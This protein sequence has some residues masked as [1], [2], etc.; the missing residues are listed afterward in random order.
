MKR[1]LF[2]SLFILFVSSAH[3]QTS[4]APIG[5]RLQAQVSLG[6][7]YSLLGSGG[8][9]SR[10]QNLRDQGL[11]YY[12]NPTTGVR[13]N[14][15]SYG[16]PAGQTIGLSFHIPV[17]GVR[18]LLLGGSVHTAMTGTQPSTGGYEEGY[19]FNY[20]LAGLSAKY[21]PWTNDGWFMQLDGGLG[22]V[23]TKNRFK[24]DAGQQRF[25]HQFGIGFGGGLSVGYT[26]LPFKNKNLG[27]EFR[28]GYQ[29]YSTRVEVDG[30]GD[31]AWSFG[32]AGVQV[33]L[34]WLR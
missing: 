30:L 18:G 25:F 5:Q 20:L 34:V 4:S 26:L 27:L 3:G 19:F 12:A 11:S 17:R 13:A 15:G 16:T 23:F 31:D 10:S 1:F 7:S 24:N 6:W 29:L 32:S 2:L 9:L 21:Y 8:E 28:G 33:G 22:S 14:V